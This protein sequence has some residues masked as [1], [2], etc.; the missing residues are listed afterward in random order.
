LANAAAKLF[1]GVLSTNTLASSTKPHLCVSC[2]D[3]MINGAIARVGCAALNVSEL[4]YR[5]E[6]DIYP[7]I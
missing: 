6:E 4:T 1:N 3:R 2:N 7:L 5:G